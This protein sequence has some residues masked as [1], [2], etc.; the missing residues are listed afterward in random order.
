MR[1]PLLGVQMALPILPNPAL[2]LDLRSLHGCRNQSRR[3]PR[4]SAPDTATRLVPE[5]ELLPPPHLADSLHLPTG[6]SR[7]SPTQE[8][9]P[10]STHPSTRDRVPL[11]LQSNVYQ[12]CGRP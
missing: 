7:D 9:S 1:G 11:H 3:C 5:K 10:A 4:N 6:F 8:G 12:P 2:V